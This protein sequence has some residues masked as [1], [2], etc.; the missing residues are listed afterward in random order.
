MPE[1][2]RPDGVEIHWEERGEGP[3]VVFAAYWSGFAEAVRPFIDEISSDHRVVDYDARGTG[4]SS[5]KGP[6]DME[7]GAGDLEAVVEEAG[8]PAVVVAMADGSNRAVRVAARRPDLVDTVLAVGAAPFGHD[9]IKRSGES[10]AASDEVVAAFFDMLDHYYES[11]LR[12]LL[13]ATN[14][15]MDEAELRRRVERQVAYCPR[16]VAIAR[17]R[18][19]LDDDPLEHGQ[20]LADRLVLAIAPQIGGPWFPARE[21]MRTLIATLLPDARFEE[22]EDGLVSRPD[23]AAAIVRRVTEGL[24]VA[25]GEA[26]R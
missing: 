7:T 15:Q 8:G 9:E 17:L 26:G 14:A 23:I 6:H 16:E 2:T 20:A 21:P 24:R 4:R 18:A 1:L 19:W 10:L 13:A 11:A 25:A 3:L 5:R 12:N 22:I